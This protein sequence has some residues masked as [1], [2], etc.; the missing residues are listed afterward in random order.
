M[1]TSP[2]PH[3]SLAADRLPAP[4]PRTAGHQRLK[5]FGKTWPRNLAHSAKQAIGPMF[6]LAGDM[7]HTRQQG[8]S[9]TERKQKCA[10]SS[11]PRVELVQEAIEPGQNHLQESWDLVSER[12]SSHGRCPREQKIPHEDDEREASTAQVDRACHDL[13]ALPGRLGHAGQ[14]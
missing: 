8:D 1:R 7:G 9:D 10:R 14:Q 6:R 11:E 2:L 5:A 4:T 12:T 13:F 3:C